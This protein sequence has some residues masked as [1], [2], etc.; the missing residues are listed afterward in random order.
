M[1]KSSK[2]LLA[3]VLAIVI[4]GGVTAIAY[5]KYIGS[6]W[7]QV[8]YHQ[9]YSTGGIREPFTFNAGTA[10]HIIMVLTRTMNPELNN[11]TQFYLYSLTQG[12][13][14]NIYDWTNATSQ[15]GIPVTME[16][17]F[18]PQNT[19]AAQ[20]IVNPFYGNYIVIIEAQ[21]GVEATTT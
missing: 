3:V 13:I 14:T 2:V 4:G 1:E 10:Y 9:G 16:Y 11:F 21:K 20:I 12:N 18:T 5:Q 8:Y 7:T 15:R 6:V 17:Y 19:V